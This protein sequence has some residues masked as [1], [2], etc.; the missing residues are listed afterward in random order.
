MLVGV[1]PILVVLVV[2][3]RNSIALAIREACATEDVPRVT[4]SRVRVAF[5]VDR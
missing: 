4:F 2:G 3:K 5:Q 1:S